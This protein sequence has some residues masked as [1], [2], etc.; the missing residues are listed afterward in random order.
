MTKPSTRNLCALP[1]PPRLR[2]LTQSIALLDEILCED[3]EFRYYSFDPAWGEDGEMASMRNGS[4]DQWFLWFGD[5]G[6]V[7]LGFDHEAS[8]MTPWARDDRSLWPGLIDG[9]PAALRYALSEPAFDPENLTFLIWRLAED[10]RYHIGPIAFPE[11]TVVEPFASDPDASAM[12]LA[13]LDDN[14][15]TYANWA[16]DY[17]EVKVDL[18]SVKKVYAHQPLDRDVVRKL[19][20]EAA[21]DSIVQSARAMG[22][23]VR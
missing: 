3:W 9:F 8:P 5:P 16:R 7:L 20:P 14:P 4:G 18:S 17:Y 6:L 19:N 15:S 10:A 2:Q 11:R 21:F 1:S 22:F 12:L 23:P 13:I